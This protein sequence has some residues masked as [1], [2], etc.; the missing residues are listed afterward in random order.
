MRSHRFAAPGLLGRGVVTAEEALDARGVVR[1]FLEA[2][3]G[4]SSTLCAAAREGT[5]EVAELAVQLRRLPPAASTGGSRWGRC[6][7]SR[8]P[9]RPAKARHQ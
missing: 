9:V 4:V 2:L 1:D 3:A 6:R 8:R 5:T 7:S